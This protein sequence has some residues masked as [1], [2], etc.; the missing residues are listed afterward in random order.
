MAS[1]ESLEIKVAVL[2][3]D[4]KHLT[5]KVDKILSWGKWALMAIGG[6]LIINVF[7]ILKVLGEVN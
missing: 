6:Y 4:I 7:D 5:E 1:D 3:N 2:S